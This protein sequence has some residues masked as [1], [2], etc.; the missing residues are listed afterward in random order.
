GLFSFLGA[1]V[2][3]YNHKVPD[4]PRGET[5]YRANMAWYETQDKTEIPVFDDVG[6]RVDMPNGKRGSV[7]GV[8]LYMLEFLAMFGGERSAS[9]TSALLY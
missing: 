8:H 2:P 9:P 5:S 6:F 3:L 4:T 1:F 7:L